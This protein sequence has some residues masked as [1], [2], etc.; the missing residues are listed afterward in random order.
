MPNTQMPRARAT[1]RKAS[2]SGD[3]GACVELADLATVVG[4]RDSKDPEG[5][6]LTFDRQ[7]VAALTTRIRKGELDL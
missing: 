6:I 5:P 7:A 1:W 3:Q 4:V 2:Y